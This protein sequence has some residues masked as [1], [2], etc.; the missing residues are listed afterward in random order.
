MPG[1]THMQKGMP[2]SV[3]MWLGSYAEA[4]LD[5]LTLIETAYDLTNQSPLGAGASYGVPL[6]LDREITCSLLGFAKVQNN[7]LYTQNSRG[8]IEANIM[9]ACMQVVSEISKFASDLLLFSTSEFNL[10]TVDQKFTTG[11]SIMPQKKNY[12]VAEVLRAKVHIMYGYFTQV[13]S[14]VLNLPS[15]YNRDFQETKKPFMEGINLT[16]EALTVC[17]MLLETLTPNHEALENS[18]TKEL[19]ATEAAYELVKKGVPFREAYKTIGES[20]DSFE[21][22]DKSKT[23]TKAN[24]VGATG[25]LQLNMIKKELK[26]QQLKLQEE[27][28]FAATVTKK[29]KGI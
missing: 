14:T 18:M 22:P 2:S 27:Q 5:H 29:L 10:F 6:P 16:K 7:S 3:G 20:L 8:K 1:Y 13:Y 26:A 11:S 15:G 17:S 4:L 28:A 12:D 21:V 9:F 19:Y 24:H 25:N 23:L